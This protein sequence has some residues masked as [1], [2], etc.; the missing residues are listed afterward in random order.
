MEWISLLSLSKFLSFLLL[1]DSVL[2]LLLQLDLKFLQI[3]LFYLTVASVF[4]NEA[5]KYSVLY[6]FRI[7][8]LLCEV[9]NHFARHLNFDLLWWN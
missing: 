3:S 6:K 2:L 9:I 7:V 1:L 5:I 4:E 8:A